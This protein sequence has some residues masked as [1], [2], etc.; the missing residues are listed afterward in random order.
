M[1][2]LVKR[3]SPLTSDKNVII[4]F[5]IIERINKRVES[6]SERTDAKHIQFEIIPQKKICIEGDLSISIRS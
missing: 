6:E 3:L 1:G 2:S 5:D 4:K